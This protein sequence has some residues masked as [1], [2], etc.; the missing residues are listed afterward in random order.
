MISPR[1]SYFRSFEA[2]EA[3]IVKDVTT[4]PR[5]RH[6]AHNINYSASAPSSSIPALNEKQ[7]EATLTVDHA[8]ARDWRPDEAQ[9]MRDICSASPVS[10][11]TGADRRRR[12]GKA[13]SGPGE[14][15]QS[16]WWRAS[17][18]AI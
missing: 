18:N 10:L 8:Q 16:R 15:W 1:P 2:G 5:T 9:L 11:Q 12:C 4:D 6:F 7:W 17:V 14:P 3:T 13:R